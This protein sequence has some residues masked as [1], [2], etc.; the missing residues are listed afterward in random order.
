MAIKQRLII[1]WTADDLGGLDLSK[2]AEVLNE[3]LQEKEYDFARIG[4]DTKLP[5]QR[6]RRFW[7]SVPAYSDVGRSFVG[8]GFTWR[9]GYTERDLILMLDFPDYRKYTVR[10]QSLLEYRKFGAPESFTRHDDERLNDAIAV[11]TSALYALGLHPEGPN[12][13]SSTEWDFMLSPK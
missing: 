2:T 9:I 8:D 1:T 5:E 10:N 4:Y 12:P 6:K 3:Q 11:A 7:E 13:P